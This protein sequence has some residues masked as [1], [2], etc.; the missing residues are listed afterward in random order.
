MGIKI[1]RSNYQRMT[2]DRDK[3]EQ[4]VTEALKRNKNLDLLV[5]VLPGK[6]PFYGK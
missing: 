4:I 2:S 5:V 1:D 6:T 3:P